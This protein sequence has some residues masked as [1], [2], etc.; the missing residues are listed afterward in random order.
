MRRIDRGARVDVAAA[1][2]ARSGRTPLVAVLAGVLV[3]APGGRARS[4]PLPCSISRGSISP[5]SRPGARAP[6]QRVSVEVRDLMAP[7]GGVR[8]VWRVEAPGVAFPPSRTIV[9]LH[10]IEPRP[11]PRD[12]G[13]WAPTW[14]STRTGGALSGSPRLRGGRPRPHPG[15]PPLLVVPTATRVHPCH[16]RG[17]CPRAATPGRGSVTPPEGL[18]AAT[19][20]SSQLRDRQLEM[21]VRLAPEFRATLSAPASPEPDACLV[22]GAHAGGSSRRGTIRTTPRSSA[23][24]RVQAARPA[25]EGE[26]PP[27]RGTPPG[28]ARHGLPPLLPP[29]RGRRAAA[30]AAAVAKEH[31][32]IRPR[33]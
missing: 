15:E 32:L 13:P 6:I 27:R 24:G 16:G 28:R 4:L 5:I 3:R 12:G 23:S 29:R 21:D 30:E 31:R 1:R 19:L 25:R 8:V 18:M 10:A 11:N 22:P 2:D 33:S 20:G 26:A 7:A 17:R 14:Q 9:V